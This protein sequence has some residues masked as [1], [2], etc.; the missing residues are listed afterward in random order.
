VSGKIR[1]GVLGARGRMGAAVC[2]AV[3]NEPGIEL[4]AAI[5]LGDPLDALTTARCHVVV[6]FTGPDAVMDNIAFCIKNGMAVVVGTSG[7]TAE[8]LEMVQLWVSQRPTA[9]VLIAPNFSVGAV[10]MM[11][12]AARASQF[13][14]SVEIIE[15]HHPEKLDAPSGTAL[16]TAEKITQARIGMAPSPD[17]TEHDELHAR[18][19]KV[20]DVSIHSVR[21]AG[22]VAHQEVL[23]GGAGETLTIR[24]DSFNRDSFMPGVLLAI[25]EIGHLDGLTVGLETLLLE[26]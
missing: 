9:R 26:N 4:V 1:V 19:A 10:L 14:E 15:M 6:D 17:A 21:L 2:A 11:E 3:E 7:F 24:H 20:S 5:D 16:H 18:G 13:F 23:L 25:K 22:L 8:R 12:F